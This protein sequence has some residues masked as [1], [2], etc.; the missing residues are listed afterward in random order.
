MNKS[1]GLPARLNWVDWAKF[2]LIIFVV[3]DHTGLIDQSIDNYIV[4]FH[5]PAFFIISGYLHKVT[6]APAFKANFKRLIV[7]AL[8]YNLIGYIIFVIK[9]IYSVNFVFDYHTFIV[10]PL[11][12]IFIYNQNVATPMCSI[13]WFLITMFVVKVI[14]GLLLDDK[15]TSSII[16]VALCLGISFLLINNDFKGSDFIGR[17]SIS[18]PFYVLGYYLKKTQIMNS[19]ITHLNIYYFIS[20]LLLIIVTFLLSNYNGRVGI[21]SFTF[22]RNLFLYYLIAII[23]TFGL[24]VLTSYLNSFSNKYV[25]TIS[26]GTIVIMGLHKFFLL[27]LSDYLDNGYLLSILIIMIIYPIILIFKKYIPSL[28]GVKS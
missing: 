14:M 5:M 23:G 12:G 21:F 2:I 28:A 13:M 15:I 9:K 11:L 6:N 1:N 24:F 7:P 16:I 10:K 17:I 25:Y 20:S 19:I 18:I 27:F 22:G 8:F 4:S 3:L 26:I